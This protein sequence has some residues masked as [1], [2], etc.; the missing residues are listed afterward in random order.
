M[1]KIEAIIRHG[2]LEAVRKALQTLGIRGMSIT[3][4]QGLGEQEGFAEVYRGVR[5]DIKFLPKIK[6]E[7]II[8]DNLV[9]TCVTV[10]CETARTG[11]IGDGKIFIYDVQ[12]V[13][14]IRTGEYD[15]EA[16]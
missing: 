2:R 11:E 7:L 15:Q 14:R 13:I 6:L 12:Q 1:K 10:I 16:L 3:E 8:D 9:D 4:I 5:Y